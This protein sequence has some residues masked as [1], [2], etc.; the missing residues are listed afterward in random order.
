M[1]AYKIDHGLVVDGIVT[2][3]ENTNA[4]WAAENLGGIW[5]DSSTLAWIGGTW[6]E[7]NGFQPPA[8]TP[9]E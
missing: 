4:L 6:D 2:D 5:I 1:Y 7:V 9:E 8:P 3:G